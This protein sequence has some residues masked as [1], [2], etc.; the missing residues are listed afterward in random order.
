[1]TTKTTRTT[2][3]SGRPRVP[4][5]P[6]T[7]M[8]TMTTTTTP[9]TRRPGRP[10]R[11]SRTGRFRPPTK[12]NSLQ[13]GNMP[14]DARGLKP[15]KT[16]SSRWRDVEGLG[17]SVCSSPGPTE[18]E[19]RDPNRKWESSGNW[20]QT[21][22]RCISAASAVHRMACVQPQINPIGSSHRLFVASSEA[23]V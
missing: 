15:E 21:S 22:L 1:M 20:A 14:H 16:K 4:G 7:T 5:R 10:K 9:R 11:L 12:P 23:L 8:A 18:P 3:M 2:R 13:L 19:A 17:V 6:D